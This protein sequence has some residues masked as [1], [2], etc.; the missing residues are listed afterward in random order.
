MSEPITEAVAQQAMVPTNGHDVA[1][2]QL[3]I[4]AA[5]P[6]I[7]PA[8]LRLLWELWQDDLRLRDRPDFQAAMRRAQGRY[9]VVPHDS[10]NPQTG[11]TYA[12]LPGVWELC[13][14]IW[15][16]E[17]LH[18]GFQSGQRSDGGDIWVEMHVSWGNYTH[19][20]T[21]PDAPSDKQGTQGKINKT[22]IQ[23]NQSTVTYLKRGLVCSGMGIVTAREDDD[24]ESG[25]RERRQSTARTEREPASKEPAWKLNLARGERAE[26]ER[27]KVNF[28]SE[29]VKDRL[30]TTW[31]LVEDAVNRAPPEARTDILT[32]LAAARKRLAEGPSQAQKDLEAALAR[33]KHAPGSTFA[34]MV[35]DPQGNPSEEMITDPVHWARVFMMTQWDRHQDP[36]AREN[37]LDYN[38]DAIEMARELAPQAKVLL[39]EAVMPDGEVQTPDSD[40]GISWDAPAPVEPIAF[41]A[42]RPI[43]ASG[44]PDY[45]GWLRALRDDLATLPAPTDLEGW[46]AAQQP[47]FESDLPFYWRQRGGASIIDALKGAWLPTPPWLV[48][49][50]SPHTP[51]EHD[52]QKGIDAMLACQRVEV[53][54]RGKEQFDNLLTLHKPA[55][56]KLKATAPEVFAI[57]SAAF[58]KKNAE[59][60]EAQNGAG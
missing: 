27:L 57:V 31:T 23:G 3:A 16:A 9:P 51:L 36:T 19:V 56:M 44:K 17:G 6:N 24:G 53:T 26:V 2:N 5:D 15:T 37:L 60:T 41:E 45:A 10:R 34:F 18:V 4:W 13:A 38:G 35:F 52:I 55:I 59:F 20:F 39:E 54:P 43:V 14:P 30:E 29:A 49:L 8:K 58:N 47:V 50:T 1:Q 7:D 40:P 42:V 22:D 32:A 33:R 28:A 21:C 48:D 12:G 11:S 25:H 46:T